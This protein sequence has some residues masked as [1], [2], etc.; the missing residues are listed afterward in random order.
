MP[1]A[2]SIWKVIYLESNFSVLLK[3][4]WVTTVPSK[5]DMWVLRSSAPL[6]EV[7]IEINF[8]RFCDF[9][10]QE[11]DCI[12]QALAILLFRAGMNF[13]QSVVFQFIKL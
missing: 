4:T 1:Q 7:S 2:L 8:A 10:F 11:F 5:G 12:G 6:T 13:S 3:S 9:I